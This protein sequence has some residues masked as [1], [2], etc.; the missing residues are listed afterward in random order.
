MRSSPAKVTFFRVKDNQ[1]KIQ[2]ICQK[3]QEAFLQERRLLITVPTIEAGRYID[4][5]LWRQPEESFLPH[6][7]TQSPTSEWIAITTME[8]GNLNQASCLLNLC[9]TASSFYQEY[10]DI[11]ELDD[12]TLPDKKEYAKKRLMEYK[13]KGLLVKES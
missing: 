11:Y 4:A 2:L 3:A 8:A 13:A 5:L 7:F 12:E 9:L 1:A 6:L 10:E